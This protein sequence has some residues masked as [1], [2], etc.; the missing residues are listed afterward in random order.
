MLSTS[1]PQPEDQMEGRF[2]LNVVVS[3]S[4]AIFKLLARKY[5]ALL[6]RRNPFLVL[7][8]QADSFSVGDM[9][10]AFCQ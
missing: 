10:S 2:F 5:Q 3:Q 7:L 4:P 8:S 9:T 1:A 6:I